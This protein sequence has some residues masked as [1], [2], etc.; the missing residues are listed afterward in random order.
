MKKETTELAVQDKAVAVQPHQLMDVI[1]QL[2]NSPNALDKIEVIERMMAMQERLEKKQAERE[3]IEAMNRLAPLL[4]EIDKKGRVAYE[5]K[6]GKEGMDRLYARLEDIDRAIRP[7][8]SVEGFSL[9]WDTQEGPGGKI[10]VIGKLSHIGGH[11]ENR[12]LD[13]PHDPSGSKNGIQAVGSTVKYGRR[14]LTVMFF[15]LI[16]KDDP[17]DTDGRDVSVISEDQA[18]VIRDLIAETKSNEKNFLQLIAGAESIE[19]IPTRDYKRIVNALETKKR[20]KAT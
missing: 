17:E 15:N 1:Q 5:G 10:R 2:V 9:A 11:V 14:M 7:L 20:V 6:N 8:Y 4:P 16:T 3:F 13:L 18:I 19:T 12:Q